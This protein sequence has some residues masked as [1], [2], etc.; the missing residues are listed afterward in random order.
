MTT[1]GGD[2]PDFVMEDGLAVLSRSYLLRRGSCC[3]LACRHCPYV[4]TPLEH[5]DRARRREP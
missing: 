1:G 4:G 2:E 5:P 3:G